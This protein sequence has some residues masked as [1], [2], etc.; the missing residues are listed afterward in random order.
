MLRILLPILVLALFL[1]A[2]ADPGDT[3]IV[4]T[5][6]QELH[7]FA[8]GGRD[9]VETF[10][11]P[12]WQTEFGEIYMIYR[13]ECPGPPGDCDPWDRTA[14]LF[15]QRDL[16]DSTHEDI[17]IARVITPYDI[18]G[19]GR[20]GSCEW[21]FDMLDYQS[22][23]REEVTLHS[24]C[25]TWIGGN[26]GWLVTCTF[27][28]IENPM[29]LR[30]IAVEQ[31]YNFNGLLY[32]DPSDPIDAHLELY[33]V[34]V[35]AQAEFATVRLW[36]TGH[37]QGNTHNAAEFSQKTHGVQIGFDVY[38][39]LLWRN[40][41]G[42][43][44]CSPQGGT[45]QFNR[46]GWCPGDRVYPWDVPFLE[47][48][49]GGLLDVLPIVEPFENHCRPTNPDCVSGSTCPD[50]NY[51][52]NGHTPPVYTMSGQVIF[53]TTQAVSTD[54]TPAAVPAVAILHQNYPNPF[55]PETTIAFAL[56]QAGQAVV[57]VFDVS[58]REVTTLLNRS[59]N[60][61]QHQLRFDGGGLSSGVYFARLETQGQ[62]F[63]RKMLLLK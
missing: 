5:F 6:V 40:D 57:K 60:R 51:N 48:T 26:Q 3:T 44:E 1:P 27:Y 56:A 53:W 49:A 19:S 2:Q 11:F 30:P 35:P 52:S 17:E 7:N 58:G 28:F 37:G 25:D 16:T 62:V 46:A 54:E 43:N 18:T 41:C 13:L 61:G 4:T 22:I 32:G 10:G 50:C 12:S 14:R 59:L 45:W 24:F 47:V 31:L 34:N 42:S 33:F 15:V 36:T 39:H 20:P 21:R 63:T 9:N 8:A 55:N 23:L 29:P 38:D